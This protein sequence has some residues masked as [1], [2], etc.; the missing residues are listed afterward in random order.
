MSARRL[1]LVL[2]IPLAGCIT[3]GLAGCFTI[4]PCNGG[5]QN[6][7]FHGPRTLN[8]ADI[9]LPDG[10]DI[11]LAA[12]DLDMPT[13][14]CCD[15]QGGVYVTESGYDPAA[16]QPRLL[17]IGDSIQV[18]ALGTAGPWNGLCFD[19]GN[20]YVAQDDPDGGRIIKISPGGKSTPLVEN[21]PTL[22]DYPAGSPLPGPGGY[23]YFAIGSATN[24]GVVGPDD[25]EQGLIPGKRWV[26][27]H[28]RFHDIP[29]GD[30]KL[31]GWN[32]L[33]PDPFTPNSTKV[34]GAFSPFGEPTAPDQTVAG[35]APCTGA[36]M[37]VPLA[38]GPP[39]LVAWGFRNPAGL[40]FTPDG[41]LYAVEQSYEDRGS[42]PVSGCGDLLWEIHTGLW[43]GWPDY[44]A[45]RALPGSRQFAAVGK[46]PPQFLLTDPPNPPPAPAAILPVHGMAGG[47]DFC[48][49]P[50]FGRTGQAFIAEFGDIA[51]V[52]GKLLFPVGFEV[53]RVDVATGV[54]HVFAANKGPINGPA[55]KV[56]GGGLERPI[57]VRFDP[58]GDALYVLDFGVVTVGS[59]AQPRPG[60]GALW[61]I[62]RKENP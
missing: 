47:I 33:S 3:G 53:D 28:R 55:S 2:A 39:E 52:S 30:V 10:Y 51:P 50:A 58:A 20:F 43:Y 56:G 37:R 60:T 36:I 7:S 32:A 46:P 14:L 54:R 48:A 19:H 8:P 16:P 34:T 45:T 61:K 42:R 4:T 27:R 12:R 17:K 13:G 23:L 1:W 9:A 21:L 18:L 25:D 44:F 31:T 57:T 49:N 15:D 11:T 41:F 6:V 40:A 29:G 22:G 59:R 38:G 5:G 62:T 24:S 35:Q 26:S